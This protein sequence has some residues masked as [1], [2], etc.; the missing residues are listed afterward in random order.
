MRS[1]PLLG[2]LLLA[3]A[4]L[5]GVESYRIVTHDRLVIVHLETP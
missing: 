1:R 4:A 3:V 5:I 2:F